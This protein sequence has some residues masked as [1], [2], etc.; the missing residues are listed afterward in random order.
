MEAQA[1]EKLAGER[2]V[3]VNSEKKRAE[4]SLHVARAV[5]DFLQKKLLLQADV[6][7]QADSLL[8]AGGLVK[9]ARENPTIRELL[10]RAAKE[11]APDKIEANFPKQPL[12]QAEILGTVGNTYVNI[13]EYERG[14]AF[15]QRSL[16]LDRQVRSPSDPVTLGHINDTALAYLWC[17]K[18]DLALPLFQES[19]KLTEAAQAPI[20]L[21]RSSACAT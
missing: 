20:I 11:L 16:S 21:I 14:I 1:A 17:D 2:L 5:Q 10:D 19:L 15:I 6:Q 13:G 18:L 12:V 4:E 8:G 3:Q 7:F 9:E